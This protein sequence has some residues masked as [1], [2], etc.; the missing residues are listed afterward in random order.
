M[1]LLSFLLLASFILGLIGCDHSTKPKPPSF[2]ERV[3]TSE[4]A[5][6]LA[7]RGL[8]PDWAKIE[9]R[10]M[11]FGPTIVVPIPG[12]G[13]AVFVAEDT[14]AAI[15]ALAFDLALPDLKL[16]S[17]DG[18]HSLNIS[19]QGKVLTVFHSPLANTAASDRWD[20]FFDCIIHEF[21]VNP[22]W[23][24]TICTISILGCGATGN[25]FLCLPAVICAIDYLSECIN[26]LLP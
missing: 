7:Q 5:G 11:P 23:V 1:K 18:Q 22:G 24:N 4:Q 13:A 26:L 3:Q 12:Y 20:E 10:E 2:L 8:S 17:C 21:E 9:R 16:E 25:F 14:T 19:D 15:S 6:Q